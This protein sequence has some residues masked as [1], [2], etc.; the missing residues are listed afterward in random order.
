MP[1]RPEEPIEAAYGCEPPLENR[2][3]IEIILQRLLERVMKPLERRNA[4]IL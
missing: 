2:A 3:A 4:G 1:E